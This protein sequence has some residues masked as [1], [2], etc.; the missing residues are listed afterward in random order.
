FDV[1]KHLLEYDDVL[2][3]HRESIYAE[4]EK[5]LSDADLR[6]NIRDM[7]DKEISDLV[8]TFL[9]DEHG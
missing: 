9:A 8:F 5:L 6:S 3:K 1:R 4:R 2:N 7:I